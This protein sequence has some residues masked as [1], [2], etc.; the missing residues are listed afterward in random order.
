MAKTT[1]DGSKPAEGDLAN[2][3]R[4]YNDRPPRPARYTIV[5]ERGISSADFRRDHGEKD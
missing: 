1:K 3:M 5:D 4:I 2:S